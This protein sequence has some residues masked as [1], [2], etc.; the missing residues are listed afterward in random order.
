MSDFYLALFFS[1]LVLFFRLQEMEW[2]GLLTRSFHGIGEIVPREGGE[3][4][5]QR[6]EF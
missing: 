3:K 2:N 6:N 1:F 4:R 5:A